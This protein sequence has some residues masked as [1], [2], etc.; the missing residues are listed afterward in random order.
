MLRLTLI[1]EYSGQGFLGRK[2]M[3]ICG[4]PLTMPDSLQDCVMNSPIL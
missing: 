1:S 3:S 2:Q 4:G